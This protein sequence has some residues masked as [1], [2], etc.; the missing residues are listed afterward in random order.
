[1]LG[2]IIINILNNSN[3]H[4]TSILSQY[5]L[6]VT[7]AILII[8]SLIGHVYVRNRFLQKLIVEKT[9]IISIYFSDHNAVKFKLEWR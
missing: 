6:I 9:K 5:E 3:K 1:M 2:D 7:E 4:L 8:S